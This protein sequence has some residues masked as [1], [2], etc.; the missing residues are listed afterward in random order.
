M[1]SCFNCDTPRKRG[2]R[3][4]K[5][6]VEGHRS[7]TDW[8]DESTVIVPA[9]EGYDSLEAAAAM[10]REHFDREKA[11]GLAVIYQ[12]DAEGTKEGLKLIFRNDEGELEESDLFY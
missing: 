4:G 10:A 9:D 6:Y 3:R 2:P 7:K 5:F 11:M 1:D 8:E 12:Q